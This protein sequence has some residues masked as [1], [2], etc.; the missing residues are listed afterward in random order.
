MTTTLRYD[1]CK[2]P[3]FSKNKHQKPQRMCGSY[4]RLKGI[5]LHFLL[6][7]GWASPLAVEHPLNSRPNLGRRA[8]ALCAITGD[9]TIGVP[10]ILQWRGSRGGEPNQGNWGWKS[11][12]WGPGARPG[13]RYPES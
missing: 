5:Y 9:L 8:I 3:G 13:R 11:P 2:S 12:V 10:R 4:I 1:M 7:H 6:V